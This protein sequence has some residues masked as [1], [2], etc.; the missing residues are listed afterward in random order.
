ML[1]VR[2]APNAEPT[3]EIQASSLAEIDLALRELRQ[4][5]VFSAL[6]GAQ[7][8][9]A[10]APAA[11]AEV[12]VPQA[13]ASLLDAVAE[14]LPVAQTLPDVPINAGPEP[15]GDADAAPFLATAAAQ[16]A[17]KVEQEAATVATWNQLAKERA[18]Q[19]GQLL[20]DGTAPGATPRTPSSAASAGD[21]I[22]PGQQTPKCEKCSK[23]TT[24]GAGVGKGGAWSAYF[25]SSGDRSHTKFLK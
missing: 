20:P 11:Q 14:A 15:T 4:E 2:L 12:T 1:T 21:V 3:I 6:K 17:E 5:G 16:L 8:E 9:F 13:A 7:R 19:K 24:F 22:V 10:D 23:P 25:C 18:I